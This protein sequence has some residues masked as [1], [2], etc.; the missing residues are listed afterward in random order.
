MI[1]EAINN[2]FEITQGNFPSHVSYEILNM[3]PSFLYNLN[4]MIIFTNEDA[5]IIGC[6][7]QELYKGVFPLQNLQ[8]LSDVI[9][10]SGKTDL[11][12]GNQIY[13]QELKIPIT[14]SK[15]NF[16]SIVGSHK[17]LSAGQVINDKTA[18]VLKL[19]NCNIDIKLPIKIKTLIIKGNLYPLHMLR[20]TP[21]YLNKLL[22]KAVDNITAYSI[23]INY[24]NNL[25]APY[26]NTSFAFANRSYMTSLIDKEELKEREN[27][28]YVKKKLQEGIRNITAFSLQTKILNVASASYLVFNAYLGMLNFQS[29]IKR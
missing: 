12:M 22:H 21:Y 29:E 7:L 8:I 14:L 13:F 20:M 3:M 25:S 1:T 23:G 27:V 16:L 18:K 4:I 17:L 26:I 19:M 15:D 5:G 9:L 24:L 28:L 11:R 6:K 10:P 2:Y